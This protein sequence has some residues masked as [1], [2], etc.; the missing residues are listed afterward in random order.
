MKPILIL[1]LLLLCNL[2]IK[3]Q[4]VKSFSS[5]NLVGLLEGSNGSAFQLQTINGI[6]FNKWF[7][8]IGTGL[9][10]YFIR[11][12]PVFL[13]VNHN[14][15]SANK[16][17]FISADAGINFAWM[18]RDI[19]EWG[20]PISSNFSPSAYWSGNFGYRLG[21]KNNDAVVMLLGYSFK[22]L[23]EKQEREVFCINP[24]CPSAAENFVYKLKR[25]SLRVGYQF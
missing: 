22:E 20:G 24:P 17:P 9:D 13:S 5:Q 8:G 19:N 12:V 7:T 21:L 14:F 11:S 16:T 6:K 15:L 4:E 3:A 10:Y 23:K 1:L 2:S 25:V 18:K